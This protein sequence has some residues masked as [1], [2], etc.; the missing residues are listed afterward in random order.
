MVYME[1]VTTPES[2]HVAGG[3]I[4]LEAISSLYLLLEGTVQTPT[5][6]LVLLDDTEGRLE[7]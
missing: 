7:G 3:A 6:L 4:S 5:S 1:E 2:P